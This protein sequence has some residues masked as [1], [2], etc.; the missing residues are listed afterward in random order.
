MATSPYVSTPET[1]NLNRASRV[2]LGPCTDGLRD[3][4]RYYVQPP[5]FP[6]VIKQMKSNLP[7][8]SLDQRNLILPQHGSYNGSYDDMDISL[9]QILLRNICDIPP[10][11]NG[12]SKDPDPNDKSISANIERIRLA[13]NKIGHSSATSLSTAEF[14]SIW[15]TVRAAM[16]YLDTFLQNGNKYEKHIDFLS[17]ETMNPERDQYYLNEL[18]KQVIED[19]QTREMVVDLQSQ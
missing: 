8:L 9:L 19:Q 3:T 13:R 15:V 2:V 17:C 1:T 16:V 7:K 18:R 4:L 11:S 12:W 14:T 5:T 10:H 6:S